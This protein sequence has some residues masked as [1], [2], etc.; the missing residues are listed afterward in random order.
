MKNTDFLTFKVTYLFYIVNNRNIFCRDVTFKWTKR[1][2][3]EMHLEYFTKHVLPLKDKLYRFARC[4]LRDPGMAEDVVQD[5]F[6]KLWGKKDELKQIHNIEAWSI[7]I[8]RNLLMDRLRS[9]R[10]FYK[11]PLRIQGREYDHMTPQSIIERSEMVSGVRDLIN[12]LPDRQKQVVV[13][14]EIEG[15]SYQAIGDI[16][17]IDINLV[18]VTLFRARENLRKKILNT[19]RYEL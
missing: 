19:E 13:L 2:P 9:N 7:T 5:V 6:L 15:L 8:T 16:M 11:D 4:Y 12:A 17:G 1:L 14:R 10:I 3:I 18:K